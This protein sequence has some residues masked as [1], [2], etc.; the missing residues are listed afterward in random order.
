MKTLRQLMIESTEEFTYTILSTSDIHEPERLNLIKRAVRPYGCNGVDADYY[1]PPMIKNPDFEECP[2]CPS[3][4]VKIYLTTTPNPYMLEQLIKL[5]LNF[6]HGELKVT[7]DAPYPKDEPLATGAE[8]Y[9]AVSDNLKNSKF[10]KVADGSDDVGEPRAMNFMKELAADRA[11]RDTWKSEC[12]VYET[13][14]VPSTGIKELLGENVRSGFYLVHL[15]GEDMVESIRIEG[16]YREA[17]EALSYHEEVF[18]SSTTALVE[19]KTHANGV[20]VY[21]VVVS[22]V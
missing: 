18:E 5:H 10:K 9:A 8:P 4:A 3:Y 13:I 1:K 19:S 7:T 14:C 12:A 16:P 22:E 6:T 17:P 21:E 2:N 11:V 20:D 15:R